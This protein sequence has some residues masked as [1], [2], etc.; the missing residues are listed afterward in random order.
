MLAMVANQNTTWFMATP[1]TTVS[2]SSTTIRHTSSAVPVRMV[3]SINSLLSHTI[4][5]PS[6]T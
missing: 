3:S 5:S 2:T 4:S 1:P 6:T